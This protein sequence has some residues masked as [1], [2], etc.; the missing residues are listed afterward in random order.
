MA[1]ADLVAP[2]V[3]RLRLPLPYALNHV[4]AY[5]VEGASGW[6][7]ID[8]G[9]H[10]PEAE[11]ALT[12]GLAEAGIAR[13]QVQRVFVTHFHPDHVG[14]AGSFLAAG[15]EVV[16]HAPEVPMVRRMWSQSESALDEMHEFL[17]AFGLPP[18]L[19]D[20][21]RE[22][23]L[24]ARR[25]VLPL[26]TITTVDDGATL[27]LGGR[28]TRVV[29][30]PGHTDHHA[31]LVEERERLLFAGDHVLPKI[32]SNIG[33]YPSAHDDPLGDY[34]GALVT[35]A[36]EKVDRVLPAHGDPFDDLRG[37]VGE[38]LEHHRLRLDVCAE[39]LQAGPRDAYAVC[40]ALFPRLRTLHD[41][42]FAFV[43]TLAH[44]RRLERTGR[45]EPVPGTPVLWRAL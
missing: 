40:H 5:L 29:W 35:I 12:A 45:V 30:T 41:E 8:S 28:P 1:A 37:R 14:M 42:R 18:S 10:Y 43:E 36:V 23:T 26:E 6:A 3:R 20:A 19:N 7:L 2:G 17:A 31:A 9:L 16:M 34:L 32:S 4:N 22:H 24:E 39:A 44:L 27:D 33:L 15:S 13:A 21:V 38:L 11:A 25:R